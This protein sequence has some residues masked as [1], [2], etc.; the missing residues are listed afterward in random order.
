M[1]KWGELSELMCIFEEATM[2][3][4]WISCIVF[5]AFAGVAH[6]GSWA[7]SMFVEYVKDFGSVPRGPTLI[8]EFKVKNN[9]TSD[10]RIS[11]VRVSCGCVNASVVK[12][13]LKPNEETSVVARMDSNRFSGS[14]SVT[15]YVT[16]DR[17]K[18]EEVRLQVMAYGRNDFAVYPE[19]FQFAQI[20]RGATP[21]IKVQVRFYGHPGIKVSEMVTE[22]N[23]LKSK[24]TE[25]K[26][27][28][29]EVTFEASIKISDEIP[30]GKWYSDVWLKSN[31]AGIGNIRVP[32]HVEVEAPLTVN[33]QNLLIGKVKMGETAEKK[34]VV[35]GAS[36][37]KIV[38]LE[39]MDES[40][41][42]KD[43]P[44]DKKEVHVITVSFK[45]NRPGESRQ[46]L[47]I[48]TDLGENAEVE[49]TTKAS[50]ER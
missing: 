27:E 36:P 38:A 29:S 41:Q 9:T 26:R 16:F 42:I 39:G 50:V 34:I 8:H 6:G 18:F 43:L 28:G 31:V 44:Q 3:G 5:A 23:Y 20:K 14:K 25:I 10:V 45:A 47:I 32:V 21:E 30:V 13:D 33:P 11:N 35:R 2:L 48:K 49:F 12:N 19:S 46:K 7:D 15:I 22:S 1:G 24:V 4:R 40:W 37:F 17:P